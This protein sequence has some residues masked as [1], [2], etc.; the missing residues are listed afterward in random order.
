MK[1]RDLTIGQRVWVVRPYEG[2]RGAGTVTSLDPLIVTFERD[3]GIPPGPR[4]VQPRWI[5]RTA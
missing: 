4:P 3:Y 5:V 2:G 1:R